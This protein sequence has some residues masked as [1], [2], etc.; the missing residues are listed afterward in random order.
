MLWILL[1]SYGAW[2]VFLFRFWPLVMALAYGTERPA[3][4]EH[5]FKLWCDWCFNVLIRV[6]IVVAIGLPF[7]APAIGGMVMVGLM[8]KDFGQCTDI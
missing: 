3:E 8:I 1:G 6:G 4:E 2:A 7:F 5:R